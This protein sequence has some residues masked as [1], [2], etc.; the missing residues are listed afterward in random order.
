MVVIDDWW[1]V[2]RQGSFVSYF[3]FFFEIIRFPLPCGSFSWFLFIVCLPPKGIGAFSLASYHHTKNK[4]DS[5]TL[6]AM[7]VTV[8]HAGGDSFHRCRSLFDFLFVV[9]GL[10]ISIHTFRRRG[11][12]YTHNTIIILKETCMWIMPLPL[13]VGNIV[14]VQRWW[15]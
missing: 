3:I 1:R 4:K 5:A 13:S 12:S 2:L 9:V 6:A 11:Y 8:H 7:F 14:P 10:H 15:C